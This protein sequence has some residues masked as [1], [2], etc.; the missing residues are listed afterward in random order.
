MT[1]TSYIHRVPNSETTQPIA[2]YQ[3]VN[4]YTIKIPAAS[5]EQVLFYKKNRNNDYTYPIVNQT[6]IVDLNVSLA[7]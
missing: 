6:S 5:S 4:G 7:Q 1:N 2:G 3:Y